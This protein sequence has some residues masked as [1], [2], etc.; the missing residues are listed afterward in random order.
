MRKRLS[1]IALLACLSASAIVPMAA[2]ATHL[3]YGSLCVSQYEDAN[4]SG[5][6]WTE[7]GDSVGDADYTN[8][9]NGL[10]NGCNGANAPFTN[11]S[12]NDCASSAFIDNLP[13]G[14]K[15]VFYVNTGY[16]FANRCVST[17]GDTTIN[18]DNVQNDRTSSYRVLAG[19]C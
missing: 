1:F 10:N 6:R 14:F 5:D 11:S 3:G 19:D 4:R 9:T 13:G 7:C 2:Q 15:V 18:F 17:N 8:N 12:W 16:G